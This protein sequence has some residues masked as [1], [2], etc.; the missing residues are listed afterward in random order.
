MRKKE[1]AQIIVNRLNENYPTEII[2]YLNYTVDRPYELL[3]ATIMSAQCT[4]DRVNIVT[5][6][7]F[8]KYTCLEDYV[9]A[10]LS[11]IEDDIRQI[12]FFRNKAKSLK[13]SAFR[14]LSEYG[15]VLPSD[16]DELTTLAGVGRK[17]ANV[18]RCH[19]FNIPS[20]VVDTHVKRI[21]TKLG[22]TSNKDPVK[23]ESDLVKILP[24]ESWIAYNHQVIAHGRAICKA[25]NPKCELC[26]FTD[27]CN[28]YKKRNLKNGNIAKH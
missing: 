14:L 19:I 1:K 11:Q 2:C 7:L 10:P 13:D 20:V 12:N 27:I 21:T 23:I 9:E 25:P 6:K 15:G 18:V 22:L 5:E 3:F 28:D 26:F 24:K 16:I 4:D 17:T 8:K